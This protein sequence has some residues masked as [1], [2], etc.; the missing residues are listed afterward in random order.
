M[1]G[2]TIE[3]IDCNDIISASGAIHC[4]TK[5]IGVADPLLINHQPLKDQTEDGSGLTFHARIR[6][7]SGIST[8]I[9]HFT[10]DTTQ[11]FSSVEMTLTDPEN[12]IYEVELASIAGKRS[13]TPFFYYIEATANN[14]KTI[15]RPMPG[16][17]GPWK[18]EASLQTSTAYTFVSDVKMEPVF[19]NPAS[20]ITCIP[21]FS[22]INQEASI[23][24]TDML[25]RTQ[26]M[27]FMGNLPKGESKYFIQAQDF[28]PGLY[29]ITIETPEGASTQKLLIR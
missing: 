4:I 3:G 1:P 25:G 10:S 6:H 17:Q 8:A 5:E 11:G 15:T 19:P 18:F 29:L 21:V 13:P 14:G 26:Q 9:L 7:R 2:Y 27:I 20:A 23:R 16:P 24:L 12:H 28:S 22:D